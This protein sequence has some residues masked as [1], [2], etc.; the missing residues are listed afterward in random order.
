MGY[1]AWNGAAPTTAA[2]VSVALA[3]GVKT[4]LQLSTPSD[5]QIRI[6]GWGYSLDI[7][8]AAGIVTV[9]LMETDVAATVTA[10]FAAGLVKLDPGAANSRLTLGTANTGYT[11]SAEGTTTASRMFDAKKIP[12][13]AG[14][15]DLT[16]DKV[17]PYATGPIVAV[18]KFARVRT[19]ASATTPTMLCYIAY[20]QL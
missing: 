17:W 8:P 10:H 4:M 6:D 12:V 13:A 7:A 3:N 14:S 16:Y 5:M 2:Q 11:A 18:S 1:I 9:E 15:T 20:T 19:T